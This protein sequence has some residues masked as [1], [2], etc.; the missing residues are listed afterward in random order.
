M[1]DFK[2]SLEEI[3]NAIELVVGVTTGILSEK[4]LRRLMDAVPEPI[5]GIVALELTKGAIESLN[6]RAT[7]A[8]RKVK[9]MEE[10]CQGQTNIEI[11]KNGEPIDEEDAKA[12]DEI[13]R[14]IM[15][16]DNSTED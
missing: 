6:K 14:K 15:R 2:F 8:E 1:N 4:K 13:F 16:G 3:R 5:K 10:S 7:E 9:K 11:L 12:I